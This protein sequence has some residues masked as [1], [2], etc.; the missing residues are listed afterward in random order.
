MVESNH[1]LSSQVVLA[2]VVFIVV[3]QQTVLMQPSMQVE[4]LEI[5][6]RRLRSSIE[7]LPSQQL[8]EP[9]QVG[10]RWQLCIML[11]CCDTPSC[12]ACFW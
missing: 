8:E 9:E 1:H 2:S 4:D 11:Y 5:E 10:D 12:L 6:L 7:T 3:L